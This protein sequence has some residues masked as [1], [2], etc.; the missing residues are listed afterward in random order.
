M[1]PEELKQ[2][3]KQIVNKETD[4]PEGA[5]NINS[6]HHQNLIDKL[7]TFT[8]AYITAALFTSTDNLTYNHGDKKDEFD[9]EY[10]DDEK[11]GV[12]DNGGEPL[13]KKYT[14]NDIDLKTLIKMVK[15]CREFKKKYEELYESAGWDDEQAGHDFWLTRNGHGAGFWSRDS[16]ELNNSDLFQQGG[17]EAIEQVGKLLTKAAKSYGEYNLYLGDGESDGTIFGG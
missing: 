6:F 13:D 17:D 16:S 2:L 9:P 10:D 7:D 4:T 5:K 14:I 15:D 11:S 1:T 8:N 12:E 3:I